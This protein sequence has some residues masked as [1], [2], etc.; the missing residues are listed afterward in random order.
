ML[1]GGRHRCC[2]S[3]FCGAIHSFAH[4]AD[5][6]VSYGFVAEGWAVLVAS[7]LSTNLGHATM[8][9]FAHRL[10]AFM[11]IVLYCVI[12]YQATIKVG[13]GSGQPTEVPRPR[14]S[15]IW[16]GR[17]QQDVQASQEVG[18]RFVHK[19]HAPLRHQGEDSTKAWYLSSRSKRRIA[20]S[21]RKRLL[22]ST[23]QPFCSTNAIEPQA[24][25]SF[26]CARRK[27]QRFNKKRATTKEREP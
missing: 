4:V 15:S 1:G 3:S 13:A 8:L 11:A 20:S 21:S 16:I 5:H 2:V 19:Q 10:A 18:R 26:K 24:P 17:G 22:I 25:P 6:F 12:W 7:A 23:T 9:R 14:R 27:Q